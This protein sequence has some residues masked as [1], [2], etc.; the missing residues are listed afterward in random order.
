MSSSKRH[1]AS[2]HSRAASTRARSHLRVQGPVG[3]LLQP[4]R[5]GVGVHADH[6]RVSQRPGLRPGT[7]TWPRWRRSKHAV[8][9]DQRSG[10]GVARSA[11]ERLPVQDFA[12]GST[13]AHA[14]LPFE[15]V[16]A[17]RASEQAARRPR[18]GGRG[19]SIGAREVARGPRA[20]PSS[21]ASMRPEPDP[22]AMRAA[23][24]TPRGASGQRPGPRSGA[25]SAGSAARVAGAPRSAAACRGLV[26]VLPG[27]E[28]RPPPGPRRGSR[29]SAS[30]NS[31][32]RH[33]GQVRRASCGREDR[34]IHGARRQ[35]GPGSA[36]VDGAP[37]LPHPGGGPAESSSVGRP[38]TPTRVPGGEA[39]ERGGD[40]RPAAPA[41]PWA[42]SAWARPPTS[43][44]TGVDR[45]PR[46]HQGEARAPLHQ[47][48]GRALRAFAGGQ[49]PP[50]KPAPRIPSTQREGLAMQ[51]RA[52]RPA[53]RLTPSPVG[54]TREVTATGSQIED[55]GD[56]EEDRDPQHHTSRG[57]CAGE[58][59]LGAV[60]AD[61]R[62]RRPVSTSSR[63]AERTARSTARTVL[64]RPPRT[65]AAPSRR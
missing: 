51:I 42:R 57:P 4:P 31:V 34:R 14:P 25:I 63:T 6:Q 47:R 19:S 1:T 16:A 58:G 56:P 8:R 59:T 35:R 43:G 61:R 15:Q 32:A 13:A 3:A 49:R 9:E 52:R 18:P 21:D 5:R 11:H 36:S 33:S 24:R 2:T 12:S 39:P 46:R 38:A 40:H 22:A 41:R 64:R 23:P 48:G 20:R 60:P 65:T 30:R 26:V 44:P 54:G 29:P 53:S 45:A 55:E 62:L 7:A 28:H 50:A 17:P 37:R 10:R 27:Q